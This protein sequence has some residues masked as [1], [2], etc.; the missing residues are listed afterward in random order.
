MRAVWLRLR[1]VLNDM[2]IIRNLLGFVDSILD[3][4]TMYRVILYY[5]IAILLIAMGLS[6]FGLLSYDPVSIGL[7]ALFFVFV[8]EWT[9][10]VFSKV[11]A[12]PVNVESTTI[13]A[14]ILA[15]I[16]SPVKQ[17]SDFISIAIISVLAVSSKYILA[18]NKKHLFNPAALAVVL[19]GSFFRVPATWWVGNPALAWFVGLGGLLVMR[20]IRREPMIWTFFGTVL[21][22]STM[23]AILKG[24]PLVTLYSRLFLHSSLLFLAFAMLTEPMTSPPVKDMQIVFAAIVGFLFVPDIHIGSVYST[25]ELALVA[26][27][28]FSYVVSPKERLVLYLKEKILHSSDVIDFVFTLPQGINHTPGQYME[29]TLPHKD[30]DSRGNRRYFTLASSPTES[31]LRLGVKFYEHSSSF[32]KALLALGSGTPIAASQ[33]AG[34]FVLPKDTAQKLVFI[35]G[36]IGV[37]PYRSIIKYLVDKG[38]RRDIVLMYANKIKN[39]I[40]YADIFEKARV[41]LGMRTIYTL[42]DTAAIPADWGGKRGRID[43]AMIASEIPDFRDRHFY[44]SGPYAMVTSYERVLLGMGVPDA[45]IKKDF[46]P[47]FV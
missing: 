46:F 41:L 14:L 44:L 19:S 23:T 10:D 22:V 24:S 45:Q 1:A 11:F 43:S 37:T 34:D 2:S 18:I 13:T 20:K 42:T 15:C 47:G 21:L 36:G 26:G 29:W 17:A 38:E 9:N 7:T 8:S 5:L 28:V 16:V 33:R 40:V 4:I 27:N 25:P 6:A 31:E 3:R 12:V 35:A 32:K 39:D 30:P